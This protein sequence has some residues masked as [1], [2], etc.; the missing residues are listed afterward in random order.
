[1]SWKGMKA[2][3]NNPA[4]PK[5]PDYGGRGIV[6]H[7]A[8][9]TYEGFLA[10]LRANGMHPRPSGATLDRINM[11]GDYAPG[12]LR[13]STP[14]EQN[15]N[16]RSNRLITYNGETLCLSEWAERVG[17]SVKTLYTR[18]ITRRWPVE[19]ALTAPIQTKIC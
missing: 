14:T 3:C 1:M 17:M 18:L 5:F 10:W 13:W 12:N 15:R 2:R 19:R 9:E 6:Y 4:H 7:A 8:F 11:N 16:A